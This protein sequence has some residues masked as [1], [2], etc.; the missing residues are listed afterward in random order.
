MTCCGPPKK[1]CTCS[2]TPPSQEDECRCGCGYHN[3]VFQV[4]TAQFLVF[5]AFWFSLT[6]VGD[7]NFVTVDE[8]I[9]VR[10]D[11]LTSDRLG[12]ITY[13]LDDGT[14]YFYDTNILLVDNSTISGTRTIWGDQQLEYYVTEILGPNWYGSIAV[15]AAATVVAFLTFLYIMSYCCSAQVRGV[16]MFV[17]LFLSMIIVVLQGMSF[18]VMSSPWCADNGCTMGRGGVFAIAAA[19]CFFVSGSFF[20]TMTN[21]PGATALARAKA[22]YEAPIVA[23]GANGM[24]EEPREPEPDEEKPFPEDEAY[25]T[26][27]THEGAEDI[28]GGENEEQPAEGDGDAEEDEDQ[29]PVMAEAE[30]VEEEPDLEAGEAEEAGGEEQPEQSSEVEQAEVE[31]E[32]HSEAEEAP[33]TETETEP[34]AEPAEATAETEPEPEPEAGNQTA[35]DTNEPAAEN[36]AAVEDAPVTH[37]E[38]TTK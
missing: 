33:A 35:A 26:M 23:A 19:T 31:P 24:D 20:C 36:P 37:D 38:T 17:G 13:Q 12:L 3:G 11:G 28:S 6:V 4:I 5:I 30:V 2:Y 18:L 7:C 27:E 29:D 10:Q 25:D 34:A 22:D 16:R 8:P 15:A 1:C 21:Y 32:A 9:V 14:C